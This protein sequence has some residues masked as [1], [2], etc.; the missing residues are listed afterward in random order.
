MGEPWKNWIPGVLSKDQ[1]KDLCREGYI[2]GVANWD[3]DNGP[4]D[5]SA[6]DLTLADEGYRMTKGSVK[7]FGDRYE[8]QIKSQ[9]LV[10]RLQP[11]DD[12]V[13][14]LK[15]T[16]TYLFRLKERLKFKDDARLYGQATAKSTIGRM[17]VLARLI[18][19]GADHYEGFDLDALR[20][21]S[22]DMYIEITPMTFNVRVKAGINLSQLRLFRGR[23]EDSEMKGREVYEPLLHG[24]PDQEMDGSLS[25]D[26]QAV[27]ISDNDVCAFWANRM[28]ENDAPI[29][30]WKRASLL[31]CEYWKFLKSDAQRRITI[32]KD[33]FY[34][35]RSK[36]KMSLTEG[37]AVY[38]RASDERIGEMRIHYAG[39]VHPFFGTSREDGAPGTSLIFEVRGH[40]VNVSLKDAEKMAQLVFYRMSAPCTRGAVSYNEQTLQLSN[41]FAPWPEKIEVGTDGTVRNLSE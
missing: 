19:D 18:V 23:P 12:G 4:I 15:A 14:V 40:D 34:I 32:Q 10:E 11:D 36:E 20:R 30:L 17:D 24:Q 13:Y 26:L 25:V 29:D 16:Q 27:S 35:L 28:K 41:I 33:Y 9:Q 21:G 38:C 8:S 1:L 3:D 39:F 37:V 5:Y 31:P 2:E 6:L 22:G 7:P